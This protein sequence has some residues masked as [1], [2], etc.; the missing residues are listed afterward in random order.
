M[1]V[2]ADQLA[3]QVNQSGSSAV[4]KNLASEH[5]DMLND[6]QILQLHELHQE[7]TKPPSS[8]DR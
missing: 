8:I 5:L 2:F 4:G 7:T 3:S 1:Q 6:A